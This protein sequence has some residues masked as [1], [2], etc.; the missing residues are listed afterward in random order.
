MFLGDA[1]ILDLLGNEGE[2]NPNLASI[3]NGATALPCLGWTLEQAAKFQNTEGDDIQ[4]IIMKI[5]RTFQ[6]AENCDEGSLSRIFMDV[7]LLGIGVEIVY[8]VLEFLKVL[9]TATSIALAIADFGIKAIQYNISV[10]VLAILV[11][12]VVHS[13]KDAAGIMFVMNDSFED[14]QMEALAVTHGKIV[15]IF[16][17][18]GCKNERLAIIPRRQKPAYNANGVKMNDGAVFGGYMV[19]RKKDNATNG[20]QGAFKFSASTDYPNGVFAGWEVPIG[21]EHGR[22]L[23]SADFT[24]GVEAWSNKANDEG[25]QEDKSQSSTQAE[26]TGRVNSGSAS[27]AYYIVNIGAANSSGAQ[28]SSVED[29]SGKKEKHIWNEIKDLRL[30]D[31]TNGKTSEQVSYIWLI[32]MLEF[33]NFCCS[34]W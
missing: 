33:S 13:K 12:I 7:G 22:L 10:F 16:K 34:I 23:V 9:D 27:P 4:R 6:M 8:A 14:M 2:A 19:I 1:K 5:I 15:G 31:Y 3:P 20:T 32:M 11:P 18:K 30:P 21:E 24:G 26:V 28:L 25:K 29:I 17:E